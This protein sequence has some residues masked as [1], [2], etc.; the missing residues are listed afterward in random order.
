MTNLNSSEKRDVHLHNSLKGIARA[1][2]AA[3]LLTFSTYSSAQTQNCNEPAVQYTANIVNGNL[4][5]SVTNFD[6]TAT[7]TWTWNINGIPGGPVPGEDVTIPMPPIPT[8]FTISLNASNEFYNLSCQSV[9]SLAISC[10]RA[11][12]SYEYTDCDQVCFTPDNANVESHFWDFGDGSYSNEI[13]PCHQYSSNGTYTVC[14][15]VSSGGSAIG[16]IQFSFCYEDIGINCGPGGGC[17]SCFSATDMG[18]CCRL[19]V[20]FQSATTDPTAVHFWDFG[21]CH[22]STEAN[23]C[24]YYDNVS[25]YPEPLG[26][27]SVQ[28]LHC[29]TISGI[30]EC[31]TQTVTFQPQFYGIYA[32]SPDAVTPLTVTD[33][34]TGELLFPGSEMTGPYLANPPTK[35]EI[36]VAGELQINKGY[37]F[38]NDINF[39]LDPCA[40]MTT[41]HHRNLTFDD[42][43]SLD[44]KDG[45]PLW[46]SIDL[47]FQSHLTTSNDISISSSSYGVRPGDNSL[48]S[49]S[50]TY[51]WGNYVCMLA[52]RP[53]TLVKFDKNQ[54]DGNEEGAPLDPRS[55]ACWE[56]LPDLP[57]A[58][59]TQAQGFA[60]IVTDGIEFTIPA[61]VEPPFAGLNLFRDLAIGIRMTNTNATIRRCFFQNITDNFYGSFGGDGIRFRDVTGSHSLTQTGLG[62]DVLNSPVTFGNSTRGIHVISDNAYNTLVKSQNNQM[63]GVRVGYRFRIEGGT[64]A[65]GSFVRSNT[66]NSNVNGIWASINNA[67]WGVSHLLITANEINQNGEGGD[68]ILIEDLLPS[69]SSGS[70]DIDIVDNIINLN[71]GRAGIETSNIRGALISENDVE[72]FNGD[73]DEHSPLGIYL[74]GGRINTVNCAN[75]VHGHL[76]QTGGVQ[77]GIVTDASRDNIITD[78]IFE[79]TRIGIQF[80]EF[81]GTGTDLGCNTMETHDVGLDYW[82]VG[83]SAGFQYNKGNAWIGDWSNS[84]G[85]RHLGS[86]N[87][88]QLSLYKAK[89]GTNQWPPSIDAPNNSGTP[90]FSSGTYRSCITSCVQISNPPDGLNQGDSTIA[91]TGFNGSAAYNW[92]AQRYLFEKLRENPDLATSNSLMTSFLN[93]ET[94]TTVGLLYNTRLQ[95]D[96]LLTLPAT[97][98]NLL[99]QNYAAIRNTEDSIRW[100][101]SLLVVGIYVVSGDSLVNLRTAWTDSIS[102][103]SASNLQIRTQWMADRTAGAP[104]AI[105]S[106]NQITTSSDH[107]QN[108]K[109]L[110]HIFLN[111]TLKGLSLTLAQKGQIR[112]IAEQCPQDGGQVA[113]W[114]RAWYHAETGIHVQPDSCQDAGEERSSEV[115]SEAEA[116]QIAKVTIS[117]NPA[118]DELNV[119]FSLPDNWGDAKII[120]SNN[121]G[122][123]LIEQEA[124]AEAGFAKLS[125]ASFP[126]GTYFLSVVSGKRKLTVEK[127]V[128]LK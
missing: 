39:C 35:L 1:L 36:H 26:T 114:A 92:D 117:P 32:G 96:T 119:F 29:V 99:A 126:N 66:I 49:M 46:R 8:I 105:A 90:W 102:I 71:Y 52:T 50:D 28:V 7:Y 21:D 25:I 85:A 113:Y 76:L 2:L 9:V 98:Q 103:H 118:N 47:G 93:T 79:N 110:H 10:G 51:F 63:N 95:T 31:H 123:V 58:P 87:D 37:T 54:F 81:C 27:T 82:G 121:L 94:N 112:S 4:V 69:I 104:A 5:F 13:N 89:T 125:V 48:V 128:I 56:G 18:E 24:N 109:T 91:N 70:Q 16:D 111:T 74:N 23:P 45:C 62:L 33:C 83:T 42:G 78:N 100:I 80:R 15:A 61:P 40:G 65:P 43:V 68:G 53:F 127:I 57:N 11:G 6:P 3:I 106:N 122:D 17:T 108:E 30:T 64:L 75:Y 97:E 59:F 60:G 67:E 107:D 115:V 22:T 44:N 34:F 88:I 19:K 120:L 55:L 101:D 73:N 72:I 38:K 116:P 77:H 124:N 12:F 41:L 84:T 14:H 20:C 86:N